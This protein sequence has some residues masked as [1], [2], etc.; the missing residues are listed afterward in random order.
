MPDDVVSRREFDHL[1]AR[2]DAID[3][4]GTRGVGVLQQ[5]IQQLSKDVGRLEK[6]LEQH[7][8]SHETQRRLEDVQ[9]SSA[10]RFRVN[11]TIAAATAGAAVLALLLDIA[12]HLH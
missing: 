7:E 6:T 4:N 2:V 1:A 9:K 5:Q 3:T 11:A 10:H 12:A 8:T